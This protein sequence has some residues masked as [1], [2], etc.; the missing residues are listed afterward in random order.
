MVD[1]I[2]K[3]FFLIDLTRLLIT[4][5]FNATLH[6]RDVDLLTIAHNPG[7]FVIEQSIFNGSWTNATVVKI[8]LL[9]NS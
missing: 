9:L 4:S 5:N 2:K 6:C 1:D 8:K 3:I 7:I